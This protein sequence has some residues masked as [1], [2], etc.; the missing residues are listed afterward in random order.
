MNILKYFFKIEVFHTNV[1]SFMTSKDFFL[2]GSLET[3]EISVP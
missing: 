2:I 3:P 1:S